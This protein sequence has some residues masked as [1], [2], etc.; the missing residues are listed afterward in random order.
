V[1]GELT[2]RSGRFTPKKELPCPLNRRLGG[3]RRRE[4]VFPCRCSNAEQSSLW[5]VNIIIIIIIIICRM[6]FV[7]PVPVAE[8]SNAGVCGRSPAE[9]ADSNP[10]GGI[11]VCRKCRVVR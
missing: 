3:P 1:R 9:I 10:A 7:L 8:R 11:D 4:N 5:L 6:G 2:S